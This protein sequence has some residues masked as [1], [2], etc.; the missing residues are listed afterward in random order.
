MTALRSLCSATACLATI[1]LASS[2][3]RETDPGGS[4]RTSET[5]FDTAAAAAV[6]TAMSAAS[7]GMGRSSFSYGCGDEYRFVATMEDG[8]ESVRL[9]L[10]DTTVN[11]PHVMS[12]SGARY[13]EGPY[14]YWS[15]G[16]EAGLDTPERT[17]TGCVSD[18]GG[19][20][21]REAKARGV[22]FRALGQEPGWILDVREDGAIDV[23]AD[24]GEAVYH[25]PPADPAVDPGAGRTIYHIETEAHRATIV[26]DDEPC[27][28]AMSGW[29][30]ET[31]VSLTLDGRE[32]RGC[33]RRL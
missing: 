27:R 13:G 23:E 25:L 31:T 1:A 16:E 19:P 15:Q 4:G 12:A 26:I 21:W 17:F 29:P 6:D 3:G 9:L 7:I 32:Y 20:A 14:V 8:G 5:T 11:L 24:Y 10:P 30:Y 33:G 22:R 28:D 2:C 18:E